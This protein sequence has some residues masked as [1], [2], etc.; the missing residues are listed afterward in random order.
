MEKL[1]CIMREVYYCS[2]KFEIKAPVF[3][4]ATSNLNYEVLPPLFSCHNF[5]AHYTLQY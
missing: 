2:S 1:Q 4:G 3:S 5:A